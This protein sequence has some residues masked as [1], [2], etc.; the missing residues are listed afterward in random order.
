MSGIAYKYCRVPTDPLLCPFLT[1]QVGL[2][3]R[4]WI[5]NL[6][7]MVQFPVT[8]ITQLLTHECRINLAVI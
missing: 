8:S 3:V 5:G 4:S 1:R 6:Q 7:A 2:V